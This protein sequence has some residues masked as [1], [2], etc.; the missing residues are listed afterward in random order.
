MQAKALLCVPWYFGFGSCPLAIGI[1]HTFNCCFCFVIQSKWRDWSL[2]ICGKACF[3]SSTFL[4]LIRV[5]PRTW[6]RLRN[7]FL[8]VMSEWQQ[9]HT[10][11]I[12]CHTLL[13]KASDRDGSFWLL[14]QQCQ[15]FDFHMNL[16]YPHWCIINRG[17][18][19][20]V[21]A[22]KA[23]RHHIFI[24]PRSFSIILCSLFQLL[25]R[26]SHIS[27]WLPYSHS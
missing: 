12:R 8:K 16:M 21:Y 18:R 7:K 6:H 19:V 9:T 14:S 27:P 23:S 1:K 26:C 11:L 17:E 20:S 2:S 13:R 3:V 10:S 24:S 25:P 15:E 4:L 22:K 5:V